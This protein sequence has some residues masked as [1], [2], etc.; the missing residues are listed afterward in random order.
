MLRMDL[1][2]ANRSLQASGSELLPGTANYF[3]GNDPAKWLSKLPVYAKVRYS[4]VYPGV[5]LVY[6]G[7]Q[8]QL[9][10]DFVVAP[11]ASPKS[12]KLHFAGAQRISPA[13]I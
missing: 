8:R 13:A 7:N 10:Y 3:I 9:E 1:V 2:G 4:A 5:D 11:G 6:Y 12:V